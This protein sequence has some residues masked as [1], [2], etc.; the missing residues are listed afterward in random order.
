MAS[1]KGADGKVKNKG[2]LASGRQIDHVDWEMKN[3]EDI[4]CDRQ[5]DGKVKDGKNIEG[6]RQAGSNEKDRNNL[7]GDK[8]T[9]CK[10]LDRDNMADGKLC[11][12]CGKSFKT[13]SGCTRH[14]KS[15]ED[16]CKYS[17]DV[18]GAEFIGRDVYSR[19]QKQHKS[20]EKEPVQK[21]KGNEK[22]RPVVVCKLCGQIFSGMD[23][24]RVHKN[25]HLGKRYYCT[26]CAKS[27]TTRDQLK[28]HERDHDNVRSFQ[29]PHCSAQFKRKSNLNRH[30]QQ[31]EGARRYVCHICGKA[32]VL[33]ESLT[34]HMKVHQTAPLLSCGVCAATFKYENS[35]KTHLKIH[36]NLKDFKCKICSREFLRKRTLEDHLKVHEKGTD[37]KALFTTPVEFCTLCSKGFA[38]A[39]GLKRHMR[40]H[41]MGILKCYNRSCGK[42]VVNNPEGSSSVRPGIEKKTH[43]QKVKVY[44]QI[45][46]TSQLF[47]KIDPKCFMENDTEMTV[48]DESQSELDSYTEPSQD[49]QINDSLSVSI[50]SQTSALQAKNIVTVT[51]E[52]DVLNIEHGMKSKE[53][54]SDDGSCS[55]FEAVDTEDLDEPAPEELDDIGSFTKMSD[56]IDKSEVD[57]DEVNQ[58]NRDGV[59]KV[60]NEKDNVKANNKDCL[61][62]INFKVIVGNF[63]KT[64]ETLDYD[65]D[66]LCKNKD[67]TEE[68]S[69]CP[70]LK[71]VVEE[72]DNIKCN[73]SEMTSQSSNEEAIPLKQNVA[74][75]DCKD[76]SSSKASYDKSQSLV[77]KVCSKRKHFKN[78]K[79]L[80]CHMRKLHKEDITC[81][82]ECKTC[83][84]TFFIQTDYEKHMKSVR[85]EFK[86]NAN[87]LECKFCLTKYASVASL[88]MHLHRYHTYEDGKIYRCDQCE[89]MFASQILYRNH[90][91][92]HALGKC[93]SRERCECNICGTEFKTRCSLRRH[94]R[95]NHSVEED[96]EFTLFDNEDD[97]NDREIGKYENST[98]EGE[99]TLQGGASGTEEEN[100]EEMMKQN[101]EEGVDS[102]PEFMKD[103]SYN[104]LWTLIKGPNEANSVDWNAQKSPEAKERVNNVAEEN[105]NEMKEESPP[106]NHREQET[107]TNVNETS[108]VS[109]TELDK[110]VLNEEKENGNHCNIDK[111]EQSENDI[112]ETD[113]LHS[114]HVR[115]KTFFNSKKYGKF[116]TARFQRKFQCIKCYKTFHMMSTLKQHMLGHEKQ[117]SDQPKLFSCE[118]CDGKYSKMTQLMIHTHK[119]H[120]KFSL[121]CSYCPRRFTSLSCLKL[122]KCIK[123]KQIKSMDTLKQAGKAADKGNGDCMCSVC[124][125][126]FTKGFHRYTYTGHYQCDFCQA[127]F[128]QLHHFKRHKIKSH[129]VPEARFQKCCGKTILSKEDLQVHISRHK[130]GMPFRCAVCL[131]SLSSKCNL[132]RHLKLKHSDF[133]NGDGT[134][135]N[136]IC[137]ECEKTLFQDQSKLES[138]GK[139]KTRVKSYDCE[140]CDEAF[141]T[142]TRLKTHLKNVHNIYTYL[143][144]KCPKRFSIYSSLKRHESINHVDSNKVQRN[145]MCS[146]CGRCFT[147]KD[148]LR[149]HMFTHTGER[150]YKCSVCTASYMQSGHL[151]RHVKVTHEGKLNYKCQYSG[152]DKSFYDLSVLRVHQRSHTDE[153]PYTCQQCP[154]RFRT[155]NAR[156]T[157]MRTH[158]LNKQ[159]ECH[160]CFQGL[161]TKYC[162]Q[163]HLKRHEAAE[164]M[165]PSSALYDPNFKSKIRQ[166]VIKKMEEKRFA[167]SF[168][169][170]KFTTTRGVY[171][172]QRKYCGQGKDANHGNN[173]RYNVLN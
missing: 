58:K 42:N 120:S 168:C 21:R 86:S 92:S 138:N 9:D 64:S 115:V 149:V 19:H 159:F 28:L 170:R 112:F 43:Q 162:L 99:Q 147:A 37:R 119:V 17:C 69:D 150:P 123:L 142:N 50:D 35:L 122:H 105:R 34:S 98:E 66:L 26:R 103:G 109:V 8:K 76:G 39:Y 148:S 121:T 62:D 116:A 83:L 68:G 166:K 27:F 132:D 172:H 169:F 77:C 55:S 95:I 65:K 133:R 4:E 44:P 173:A 59:T 137:D 56:D 10:V 128:T 118:L 152:C 155:S 124:G 88:K 108:S 49:I 30:I 140:L 24:F 32:F 54:V 143:C 100:P 48:E 90:I 22:K 1:D 78:K 20:Q 74:S 161:T 60:S 165:N 14:R 80:I 15:H 23:S 135:S 73:L 2:D 6:G 163:Q 93:M 61:S 36:S 136:E 25:K 167:C 141:L 46:D 82:F 139:T 33:N 111:I 38:N 71:I 129:L 70:P 57:F 84:K 134:S 131:M 89:K 146:E 63:E 72:L 107:K 106:E 145:F 160:I 171:A 117:Q 97:C 47:E 3:R 7:E 151:R 94:K 53:C 127:K 29:C 91:D 130:K 157:H 12:I 125:K 51:R 40:K 85:H 158:L 75:I 104:I 18:C 16:R 13:K 79:S 11:D 114:P 144:N 153:R 31:H 52:S 154:S 67:I 96:E 126:Q 101:F 156:K 41:R 102:G 164:K 87:A 113:R 110:T 81:R 5:T 45:V